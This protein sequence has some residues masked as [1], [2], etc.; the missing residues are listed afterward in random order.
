MMRLDENLFEAIDVMD[1]SA[2]YSIIAHEINLNTDRYNKRIVA[3][4]DTLESA[5]ELAKIVAERISDVQARNYVSIIDNDGEEVDTISGPYNSDINPN[6]DD[7]IESFQMSKDEYLRDAAKIS[8]ESGHSYDPDDFSYFKKVC[9]EDGYTVTE[10][11]FQ[12]YWE[13][14][15]E[16]RANHFN[17]EDDIDLG[18][19]EEMESKQVKDSDGFMTDYTWYVKDNDDGSETHVMIFGDQDIYT[20]MNSEP[21]AEFD[22]EQAAQE[23]FDSYMGFEDELDESYNETRYE[24]SDFSVYYFGEDET[25]YDESVDEDCLSDFLVDWFTKPGYYYV[26]AFGD[27]YICNEYVNNKKDFEELCFG[28]EESLKEAKSVTLEVKFDPYARTTRFGYDPT[29]IAKVSGKDLRDALARMVDRMALYVTAESIRENP[30]YTVEE[31]IDDIA[32]ANGDGADFVYY[33]KDLTNNVMLFEEG[34]VPDEIEDWDDDLE[35][36]CLSKESLLKDTEDDIL[37]ESVKLPSALQNRGLIP[38]EFDTK[39]YGFDLGKKY[40][41]EDSK[42]LKKAVGTVIEPL[43]VVYPADKKNSVENY[44]ITYN[45]IRDNQSDFSAMD[46]DS[47]LRLF[48]DSTYKEE[49]NLSEAVKPNIE[50][51]ELKALAQKHNIKILDAMSNGDLRME[52]AG[53]DLMK[54]YQEAEKLGLW[55][56]NPELYESVNPE[57][58]LELQ[59]TSK[60]YAILYGWRFKNQPDFALELPEEHSEESLDA[61]M[62]QIV[63][64]YN[65]YSD[66]DPKG[67]RYAR[68]HDFMFYVLYNDKNLHEGYD[69]ETNS[70]QYADDVELEYDNM[71]IEINVG[72]PTGY[73][74]TSFGN[75]LPD[76]REETRTVSFTYTADADSV[77]DF[78]VDMVSTN[79]KE[80]LSEE[81]FA[82]YESLDDTTNFLLNYIDNN[83]DNLV[84][85]Y[86]EDLIE[87]FWDH[88]ENY[89]YENASDLCESLNEALRGAEIDEFMA[90]SRKLG[91]TTLY[92]MN[93]IM[94]AGKALGKSELQ[95]LRDLDKEFN[96]KLPDTLLDGITDTFLVVANEI[97]IE[98]NEDYQRFIKEEVAPGETITQAILRYQAE[99]N[100]LDL[101]SEEVI[102]A[103][104]R[105]NFFDLLNEIKN[106]V[107]EGKFDKAKELLTDA[108]D[109][110]KKASLNESMMSELDLEIKEAGGE[111]AWLAN[112]KKILKDLK[113]YVDNLIKYGPREVNA[114]GNF[115]SMQELNETIADIEAQ[116]TELEAKLACVI[117]K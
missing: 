10:E 8:W 52:G 7:L 41:F 71:D 31:I 81:E 104:N 53:A 3:K 24:K 48:K 78:L 108:L 68:P 116:I 105:D 49:E 103:L 62:K 56:V 18:D 69:P 94:K 35:E 50:S 66:R 45:W 85:K 46:L 11:D 2:P 5:E 34:Y 114:G 84:D 20:P 99:V 101:D 17:D 33:I 21:D 36:R 112:T 22:G 70:F 87:H 54:F 113:D 43:E 23:W 97:G 79:A 58:A 82:E 27:D 75:W 95:I 63:H 86:Y 88:A 51:E 15:D 91:F 61:R 92:Q 96:G 100:S 13:Y 57:K 38:L 1:E 80:I 98:T 47:F 59:K 117:N 25:L 73:F 93:H 29:I 26:N 74:S 32:S 111:E 37:E 64:S 9:K 76:D 115:D 40:K 44:F 6:I 67:N 107:K 110:L 90:L 39:R 83:F 16:C 30:D 72:N 19:W 102:A 42:I 60:A 106:I 65:R 109:L 12:K 28:L 4:R 77:I 55:E 89:A 14:F